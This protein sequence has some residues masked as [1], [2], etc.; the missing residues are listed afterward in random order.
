[1]IENLFSRDTSLSPAVIFD[2]AKSLPLACAERKFTGHAGP[3][4]LF[5]SVNIKLGGVVRLRGGS[6]TSNVDDIIMPR[7]RRVEAGS[8]VIAKV[9]E[10]ATDV[11]LRSVPCSVECL[12]ASCFRGATLDGLSLEAGS[13]LLRI[14]DSCFRGCSLKSILIPRS[15]E[16]LG[17]HCFEGA[18]VE[19]LSFETDLTLA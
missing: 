18:D 13:R 16:Y 1:M 19:N 2:A 3:D 4:P 12:G 11:N 8:S 17:A 7:M 5:P 14:S 9:V 10:L 15:L 6:R